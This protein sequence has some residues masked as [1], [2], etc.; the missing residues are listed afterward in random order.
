MIERINKFCHYCQLYRK[1]PGRFRF[2][3]WDEVEFNHSIIVD[4][5]YISGKLV[6]YIMDE[7]TRF[8]TAC[9]LTN[10]NARA[11][12]DALWM[13]WIDTYLGPPDFII[14]DAEKN[15]VNKEFT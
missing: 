14:T 7:A 9:W 1:S 4:I 13:L 5:I 3:L 15:F 2:T 11:T 12:W 6:L 10:I 8:N